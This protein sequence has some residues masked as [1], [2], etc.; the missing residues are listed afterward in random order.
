MS[1]F[2]VVYELVGVISAFTFISGLC[3]PL[4]N[5]LILKTATNY[6]GLAA[7]I[8]PDFLFFATGIFSWIGSHLTVHSIIPVVILASI[9]YGVSF[10]FHLLAR[11]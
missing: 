5:V 3:S 11:D 6:P 8:V 9:V 7:S 4:A 1:K 10:L 2:N